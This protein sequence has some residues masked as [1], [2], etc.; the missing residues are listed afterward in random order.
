MSLSVERSGRSPQKRVPAKDRLAPNVGKVEMS[1]EQPA[2]TAEVLMP[3][4]VA[5]CVARSRL[6]DIPAWLVSANVHL[7]LLLLLATQIADDPDLVEALSLFASTD[8]AF[9]QNELTSQLEIDLDLDLL[10][11]ESVA[12]EELEILSDDEPAAFLETLTQEEQRRRSLAAIAVGHSD[13]LSGFGGVGGMKLIGA[14]IGTPERAALRYDRLRVGVTSWKYDNIPQV[15]TALGISYK[16]L[17][18]KANRRW[19]TST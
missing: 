11:G 17:R 4:P 10:K 14:P 6:R 9:D 19:M 16:P 15:L 8:I 1:S 7:I 3:P 12:S 2:A 13:G 5:V 18:A